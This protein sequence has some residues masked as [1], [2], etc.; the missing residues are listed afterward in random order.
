MIFDT[1]YLWKVRCIFPLQILLCGDLHQ[2]FMGLEYIFSIFKFNIDT[3]YYFQIV[4]VD[5]IKIL[6]GR[7]S[8]KQDSEARVTY[9]LVGTVLGRLLRFTVRLD[10]S[11]RVIHQDIFTLEACCNCPVEN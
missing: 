3:E 11:T 1:T 5:N 8:K 10:I 2:K 4:L 9:V 7:F 6:D